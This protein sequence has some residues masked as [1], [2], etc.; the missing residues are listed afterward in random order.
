MVFRRRCVPR[1]IPLDGWACARGAVGSLCENK[2]PEGWN[3]S[4]HRGICC[5]LRYCGRGGSHRVDCGYH[6]ADHTGY[7][8]QTRPENMVQHRDPRRKSASLEYGVP[9]SLFAP[10]RNHRGWTDDRYRRHLLRNPHHL[11]RCEKRI[12]TKRRTD[13]AARGLYPPRSWRTWRGC[14]PGGRGKKADEIEGSGLQRASYRAQ[15]AVSGIA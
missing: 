9:A 11:C 4:G 3:G 5:F 14:V 13:E 7:P 6:G 1:R 2:T 12:F 15:S 8:G 10:Y